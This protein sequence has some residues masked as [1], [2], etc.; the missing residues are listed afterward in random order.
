MSRI[1]RRLGKTRPIGQVRKVQNVHGCDGPVI[2]PT[3]I[4]IIFYLTG[5]GVTGLIVGTG[6]VAIGSI[7]GIRLGIL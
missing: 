3:T 5:A 1:V 7:V 2:K 4:D 6:V